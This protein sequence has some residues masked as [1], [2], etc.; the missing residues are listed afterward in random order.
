MSYRGFEM[1]PRYVDIG[2]RQYVELMSLRT[3]DR[4]ERRRLRSLRVKRARRTATSQV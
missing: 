1:D 4:R 3:S 2:R